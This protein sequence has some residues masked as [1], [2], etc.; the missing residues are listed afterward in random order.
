V[1]NPSLPVEIAEVE[2][3]DV[4]NGF[5]C[6]LTAQLILTDGRSALW[7]YDIAQPPGRGQTIWPQQD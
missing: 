2:S 3:I 5:P 6:Q 7:S 4:Q 1:S